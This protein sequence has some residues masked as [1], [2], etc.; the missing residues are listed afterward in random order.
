[1]IMGKIP[2]LNENRNGKFNLKNKTIRFNF[3][4]LH[5]IVNYEIWKFRGKGHHR[6]SDVEKIFCLLHIG[7]N[8]TWKNSELSLGSGTDKIPGSPAP[9]N[10]GRK[11]R[12]QI[13]HET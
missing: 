2:T 1:M 10:T 12:C 4:V 9:S 3:E 13:R 11:R 5:R 8:W 7:Y 6:Q